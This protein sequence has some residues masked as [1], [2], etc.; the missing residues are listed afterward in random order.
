L[1]QTQAGFA[2]F[3]VSLAISPVPGE[4]GNVPVPW[5]LCFDSASEDLAF[6]WPLRQKSYRSIEEFNFLPLFYFF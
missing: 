3:F 4:T 5:G 6:L 1:L 2:L